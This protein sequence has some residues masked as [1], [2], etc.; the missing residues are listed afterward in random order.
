[1]I[2]SK[3]KI[4]RNEIIERNQSGNNVMRKEEVKGATDAPLA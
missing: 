4:E 1:M 3:Q 2:A